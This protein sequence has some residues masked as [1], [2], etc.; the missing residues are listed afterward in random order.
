MSASADERAIPLPIYKT[1]FVASARGRPWATD[2]TLAECRD[3][4][5]NLGCIPT[6]T[7]GEREWFPADHPLSLRPRLRQETADGRDYGVSIPTPH[8]DME[9][10]LAEFK[11]QSL[12]LAKGPVA[13]EEDFR[14]VL[15]YI[16]EVAKH[17]DA[18]RRRVR[19]IREQVGED[20]L[21]VFFLP[22]P[23]ELY[24][25]FSR[26]E[27]IYF[28]LDYP[29]LL[30][31]LQAAILDTV[32]AI[33][34]PALEGGA[35]LLFFGS[36]G[37]ELYSPEIFKKHLLQ[38]SIEYARLVRDAGGI[39]SFHLCGRGREYLDMGVFA[40]IQV[41][42]VEGLGLP[43]TGNIPSL[44]YARSK[45]PPATVLRG[46]IRLDRLRNA[47]PAEVYDAARCILAELAGDRHILSGEC[48]ILFGTPAE[49]IQALARACTAEVP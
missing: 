19:D 18:I 44:S 25:I 45:I 17:T 47:S 37:T 3:V 43:P 6:V 32:K 46:N 22:Q 31:E 14:K 15:W 24:C 16:R 26:Q 20:C 21:I 42:I 5:L 35:D 40:Q 41:D 36:A 10:R 28:E 2:V 13:S 30:A 4:L 39:S 33:I 27:A 12:T 1:A 38:P 49:N 7:V 8:G 34:R 9:L 11:R 48:D 23:Y 29:E